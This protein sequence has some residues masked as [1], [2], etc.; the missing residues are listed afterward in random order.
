MLLQDVLNGIDYKIEHLPGDLQ[1]EVDGISVDTRELHSG[2]VFV[3]CEGIDEDGHHY[4]KQALKKDPSA[5]FIENHKVKF[6]PENISLPVIKFNQTKKVLP[7]LLANYYGRPDRKL[8]L[9]GITGTNGK[10]TT[11]H[12]VK[13]V[14]ETEGESVGLIGTIER[15]FNGVSE[16]VECTTPSLASTLRIISG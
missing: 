9:I 5:L 11:T 6:L 14:L 8:K 10:T 1:V 3:A 2:E 15:F 16:P 12:L 4:L 13:S 7:S